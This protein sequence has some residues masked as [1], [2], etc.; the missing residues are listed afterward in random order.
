MRWRSS[1]V[2]KGLR[3]VISNLT[4]VFLFVTLLGKQL[5]SQG[6]LG[7]GWQEFKGDSWVMRWKRHEAGGDWVGLGLLLSPA[8]LS[9]S[10]LTEGQPRVRR[11]LRRKERERKGGSNTGYRPEESGGG[12]GVR[13]Y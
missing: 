1:A 11:P 2:N 12:G 7:I 8:V 9:M 13:A 4:T 10:F 6:G 5:A 3:K